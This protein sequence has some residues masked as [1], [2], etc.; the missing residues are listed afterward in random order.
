MSRRFATIAALLGS[1]AVMAVPSLAGGASKLTTVRGSKG[2]LTATMTVGTHTPKVNA[3]WPATFTARFDGKP[4]QA[5][6]AYQ[7]VF[8]G[9]VVATRSHYRFTGSF[10]DILTFPATA[11]GYPLTFRAKVTA[12]R[13]IVNLDYPVTVKR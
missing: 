3:N 1:A 10:H 9:Q 4:V 6:V 2:A 11:V 7:F 12:H 5:A 8:A 13:L